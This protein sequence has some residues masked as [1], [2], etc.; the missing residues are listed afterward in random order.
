MVGGWQAALST[1]RLCRKRLGY[2]AQID[3]AGNGSPILHFEQVNPVLKK[4]NKPPI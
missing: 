4:G 2:L 1:F 3:S